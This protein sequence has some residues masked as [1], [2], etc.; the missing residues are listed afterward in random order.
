MPKMLAVV[1]HSSCTVLVLGP[2]VCNDG[3]GYI[4]GETLLAQNAVTSHHA[5]SI[6]KGTG[7]PSPRF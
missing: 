1:F 7:G 2:A 6:L 5:A 4:W 3:W